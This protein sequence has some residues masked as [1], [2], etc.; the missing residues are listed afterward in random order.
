MHIA[1]DAGHGMGSKKPGVYDPG[2]NLQGYQEHKLAAELVGNL[3][4]DIQ[5]VGHK[6]YRPTGLFT[7]RDDVAKAKGVDFYLSVHF[8]GGPG[9]GSEAFVNKTSATP[10][11]KKF[12][13]NASAGMARA[14]GIPN[15]GLKYADWAVLSA[16]K[17][18]AL[19]EVCFPA[20]V[21]RYLMHKE[22][23]EL[24][25]LNALF[26]AHGYKA[27][28]R[29]PRLGVVPEPT[30]PKEPPVKPETPYWTVTSIFPTPA[31]AGAYVAWCEMKII[32]AVLSGVA[33]V[34][35]GN[36][37]KSRVAE[38]EAERRGGVCPFGRIRT[39]QGSYA[40]LAVRTPYT[41]PVAECDID[42]AAIAAHAREIIG[43]V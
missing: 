26:T 40:Q 16:N 39:P 27:Y 29:L 23:V 19:I 1:L 7:K 38:A 34:A 22:A 4:A 33:V 8:N 20:D 32:K 21:Q 41:P 2:A 13:A 25:I 3:T 17:N 15:R 18:D 24:A 5:A 9:T 36:D 6:V 11:A 35:H 14:M 31:D 37:E 10:L 28:S 42:T 43:L 12:A 30:P